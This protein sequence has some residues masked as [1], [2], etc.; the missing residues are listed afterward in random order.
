MTLLYDLSYSC[1]ASSARLNFSGILAHF[2]KPSYF[3]SLTINGADSLV[4]KEIDN[5]G[6]SM[7]ELGDNIHQD[8]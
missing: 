6:E 7:T 8:V 4:V 2:S 1:I 3:K 5:S